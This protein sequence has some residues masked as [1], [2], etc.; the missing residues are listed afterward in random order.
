MTEA[1]EEGNTRAQE[2]LVHYYFD[3][4]AEKYDLKKA[5]R[6]ASECA[7]SSDPTVAVVLGISFANGEVAE[8]DEKQ[9]FEWLSKAKDQEKNLNGEACYYLGK[10]YEEGDV[11]EKSLDDA[12]HFY[13]LAVRKHFANGSESL[14]RVRREKEEIRKAEE[15]KALQE[16][17]EAEELKKQEEV[18]QLLNLKPEQAEGDVKSEEEVSEPEEAESEE[19]ASESEEAESEEEASEP[20]GAKSEE[21]VSE[22]EEVSEPEEAK[23][24]EAVSETEEVSELEEAKSE[25]ESLE[26]TNTTETAENEMVSSEEVEEEITSQEVEVTQAQQESSP[27]MQADIAFARLLQ[28]AKETQSR[29]QKLPRQETVK[30]EDQKTQES[31]SLPKEETKETETVSPEPVEEDFVSEIEEAE[32][33][34]QKEIAEAQKFEKEL[35]VL[36]KKM[37][38]NVQDLQEEKNEAEKTKVFDKADLDQIQQV[39]ANPSSEDTESAEESEQEEADIETDIETDV[40]TDAEINNDIETDIAYDTEESENVDSEEAETF[41]EEEEEDEDDEEWE[42]SA[43]NFVASLLKTGAKLTNT[44]EPVIRE[45]EETTSETVESES[46]NQNIEDESVETDSSKAFSEETE[47]SENESAEAEPSKGDSAEIDEEESLEE[48][49]DESVTDEVADYIENSDN[50]DNSDDSYDED[51]DDAVDSYDDNSDDAA[52]LEEDSKE[53]AASD[54]VEESLSD[55]Y[56]QDEYLEE[57]YAE[58]DYQKEDDSFEDENDSKTENQNESSVKSMPRATLVDD[59]VYEYEKAIIDDLKQEDVSRYVD[60]D[61][62]T[63]E[64]V[65]KKKHHVVPI[66]LLVL[67]SSIALA[68]AILAATGHLGEFVNA[69]NEQFSAGNQPDVDES[70]KL[71]EKSSDKALEE[72][73]EKE[74]S[75][76]VKSSETQTSS[77]TAPSSSADDNLENNN[78]NNQTSQNTAADTA[79]VS[80]S[81]EITSS[82]GSTEP[83]SLKEESSTPEKSVDEAETE[84][85]SEIESQTES[86]SETETESDS[87]TETEIEKESQTQTESETETKTASTEQE[88]TSLEQTE[89]STQDAENKTEAETESESEVETETETEME[90]EAESESEEDNTNPY[91]EAAKA[92][93]PTFSNE[94]YTPIPEVSSG[95]IYA[96]YTNFDEAFQTLYTNQSDLP[97]ATQVALN[98][99]GFNIIGYRVYMLAYQDGILNAYSTQLDGTDLQLSAANVGTEAYIMNGSIFSENREYSMTGDPVGTAYPYIKRFLTFGED[100]V[101]YLDTDGDITRSDYQHTAIQR[102]ELGIDDG[103]D[104]AWAQVMGPYLIYYDTKTELMYSCNLDVGTIVLL[105]F[106]GVSDPS[107]LCGNGNWVYGLYDGKL[108]KVRPNGSELQT[109]Y[110]PDDSLELVSVEHAMENYIILT[111]KNTANIKTSAENN[112]ADSNAGIKTYCYNLQTGELTQLSAE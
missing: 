18:K 62:E 47:S 96:K 94:S 8:I 26:A 21:A 6:W 89:T 103:N 42:T 90:T 72:N 80:D 30:E 102:L 45:E 79:A 84:S 50:S 28:Q 23:S 53:E 43:D 22:T 111:A 27:Q 32:S 74:H 19:E 104:V 77:D 112:S 100:K 82:A 15:A 14:E 95:C 37:A 99:P 61:E 65:K 20:E 25:K 31:E 105:D 4:D 39:E 34:I 51:S 97:G 10:F 55:E 9:A 83:S 81:A 66:V 70:A 41:F 46:E 40:E 101:Y 49:E 36:Q 33:S 87:E 91:H 63:Y 73:T 107:G 56:S 2:Y 92:K 98:T 11:T 3:Q 93:Y 29:I 85:E 35:D 5:C 44:S 75:S 7:D 54:L 106:D 59:S 24:E 76:E 38:Q 1:A 64:E 110:E 108:A 88:K 57:D 58:D 71:P 67:V 68:A 109:I 69:L 48:S 78:E 86:E 60:V 13:Q 52:D 17:K 16:Q 12:E